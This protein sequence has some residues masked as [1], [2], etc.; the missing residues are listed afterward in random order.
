MRCRLWAV[1]TIAVGMLIPAKSMPVALQRTAYNDVIRSGRTER[2]DAKSVLCLNFLHKSTSHTRRLHPLALKH[3]HRPEQTAS[4]ED[5]ITL[6]HKRFTNFSSDDEKKVFEAFFQQTQQGEE[7]DL[8]PETGKITDSRDL[9]IITEPAYSALWGKNRVIKAEWLRWLCIDLK[10]SKKVSSRGIAMV[11]ARIDGRLDLAWANVPFPLRSFNCA[12]GDDIDLNRA[13]VGG[14]QLQ[15]TFIRNLN[16]DSLT[17]ER[18]VA[19]VD[20]FR[21]TGR[22][23]L[24]NASINGTL[25]CDNGNFINPGEIALNLEGAKTGAVLLRNGFRAEGQVN[26]SSAVISGTLE[27]DGGQFINPGAI[28]FNLVG[29]TSGG[30]V[31]GHDFTAEGEVNLSY[32]TNSHFLD[33]DG[34]HFINPG[35]IALDLQ[36]AKTGTVFLGFGEA[37]GLVNFF[38]AIVNGGIVC[39]QGQFHNPGRI[40]LNLEDV[41]ANEVLLIGHFS[42]EGAVNVLSAVI[43]GAVICKDAVFKNAGSIALNLEATKIGAVYMA[44]GFKAQGEVRLYDAVVGGTLYCYG[45]EFLNPGAVALNLEG[46]TAGSINLNNRFLAKGQVDLRSAKI[47]GDLNCEGGTITN[48]DLNDSRKALEGDQI[49]VGGDILLTRGFTARGVVWLRSAKIGNNLDCSGGRFLSAG[50][51]AINATTANIHGNALMQDMEVGGKLEFES[52]QIDHV[53]LLKHVTWQATGALNLSFSKVKALLNGADGWPPKNSLLLDGFIFEEFKDVPKKA[54]TQ[55]TWLHL[56]SRKAFISQPYE[57]TATVFRNMGLQEEAVKVIIAKNADHGRYVRAPDE[58]IWYNILGP[59][60]GYGYRPWNALFCSAFVVAFGFI[61]FKIAF[62]SEVLTPASENAYDASRAYEINR[63]LRHRLKTTYP[64]FNALIYSLEAFVPLV[65]LGIK[66]QWTPNA[67]VVG[68]FSWGRVGFP[69]YGSA[70]RY[71]LWFHTI[72]GWVLTTLW[73]GGY[74]GLIKS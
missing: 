69:V 34:G 3:V 52:S 23:W 59:T 38:T 32:T 28:A 14:I 64:K 48:F 56:Q 40:A 46:I 8:T 41:T 13:R 55:T 42:A 17:V 18:D 61:I 47:S 36:G 19:L 29:I 44:E 62:L 24:R 25:N 73:V 60:I 16:A 54:A 22:V 20:G 39:E 53:F 70:V 9:R 1:I 21:A 65:K 49:Q 66:E 27:C 67:N 45:G 15:S 31:L 4:D 6:A 72:A 33:C 7:V 30:V 37:D 35:Q 51:V 12:F 58:F 57:Q 50:R 71:Y 5:L 43:T 11:G 26:L 2:E 63:G 68:K 74:T 10:A